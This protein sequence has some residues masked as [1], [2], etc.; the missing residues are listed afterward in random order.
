MSAKRR[1][2]RIGRPKTVWSGAEEADLS[3]AKWANVTEKVLLEVGHAVHVPKN[4]VIRLTAAHAFMH[5][6][7]EIR[8]ARLDAMLELRQMGWGWTK[9]GR[10][11]GISRQ[12]AWQIGTGR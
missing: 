3:H 4:P 9:I 10:V 11:L 7:D 2:G 8:D 5:M 6:E 12:R 1:I